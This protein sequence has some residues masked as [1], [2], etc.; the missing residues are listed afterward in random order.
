VRP[1]ELE[2]RPV[3][4]GLQFIVTARRGRR[5]D[6]R[7]AGV[8]RLRVLLRRLLRVR[9]LRIRLL[10]RVLLLLLRVRLLLRVLLL[11]RVRLLR[12]RLLRIRL[13]LRRVRLLRVRGRRRAGSCT[14]TPIWAGTYWGPAGGAAREGSALLPRGSVEDGGGF[15]FT[16]RLLWAT[17]RWA[18]SPTTQAQ[19]AVKTI[20]A[21][22]RAGRVCHVD[23]RG[24]SNPRSAVWLL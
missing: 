21:G 6:G 22:G 19:G 17:A 14:A 20:P 7:R 18:E 9:L 24:A 13:L 23:G 3:A 5:S 11:L 2:H 10:L 15:W 16:R 4:A 12:V 8:R 1:G